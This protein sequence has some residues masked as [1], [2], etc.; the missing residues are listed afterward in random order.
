MICRASASAP[1][2]SA[3]VQPQM[4]ALPHDEILRQPRQRS[5][6]APFVGGKYIPAQD[7]GHP[8]PQSGLW[9]RRLCFQA[10]GLP[11]TSPGQAP[12]VHGPVSPS[13]ANGLIH[14]VETV[15]LG[16]DGG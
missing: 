16:A 12:W 3:T 5:I 14:S 1:C 4:S 11:H 2:Q 10:N 9:R 6:G 8:A 7:R 15:G 13:Q